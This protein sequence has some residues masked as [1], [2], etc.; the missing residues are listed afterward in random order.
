MKFN[1][2]SSAKWAPVI[3]FFLFIGI[4][5]CVVV[6]GA[7]R[8]EADYLVWYVMPVAFFLAIL[9]YTYKTLSYFEYDSDGLVLNFVSRGLMLS[10]FINYR[11]S[12]AEFPKEKLKSF[13]MKNYGLYKSL[14]LYVRSHSGRTKKVKFNI[15]FLGGA[16]R[17]ALANSLTKVVEHNKE[18]D[19]GA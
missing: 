15:T 10:N 8:E 4:L 5:F 9:L 16:K 1:N 7:T 6:Y 2:S 17:R 3:Y 12:R 11:E 13:R 18:V 14:V 19:G